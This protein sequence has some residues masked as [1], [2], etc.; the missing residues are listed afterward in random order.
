MRG[1]TPSQPIHLTDQRTLHDTMTVLRQH[2]PLTADGYR[3]HT[4]D[5]WRLLLGAAARQTT[6]EAVC[7]DLLAAPAAN[8]VRSH[9]TT[10]L[11]T[12]AIPDLERHCNAA[13]AAMVPPW[14]LAR[15]QEVTVDFHD[16]PYSGSRA[17]AAQ[18]QI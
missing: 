17:S 3:S 14:L 7:A 13:L 6:L 12:Q 2:L 8:T 9:L 1:P 16:E 15:P 4:D 18:V 5:L 11:A 10:Q